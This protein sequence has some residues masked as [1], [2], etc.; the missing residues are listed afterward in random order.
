M[1]TEP[2][3]QSGSPLQP[4]KTEFVLGTALSATTAP[5]AKKAEQVDPHTIPG[6]ALVTVPLPEPALFTLRRGPRAGVSAV[7]VEPANGV[8]ESS[9]PSVVRCWTNEPIGA[10]SSS[11]RHRSCAEASWSE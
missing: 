4:T 7:A 8:L 9:V 10:R 11:P 3:A 1:V 2:F 5:S 6:G